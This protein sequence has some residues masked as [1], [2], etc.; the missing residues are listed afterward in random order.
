MDFPI[1]KIRN[2]G[3][4]AH[5]DAG[6][7]TVTER[8]LFASGMTHKIGNV[9]DGN[10]V[11]DWMDQE[12]ERGITIVSAAVTTHW[13]DH[14]IN[15]IDTPGHVDFTAEVERSLRVL[16]GAVVVF[17]SVSGVQPQSETVWR[18]A[19]KYGVPRICLINK[20]D[21]MGANFYRAVDM[22]KD[23]FKVVAVPIQLPIGSESEF[24]GIIDLI[25]QR[26]IRFSRETGSGVEEILDEVPEE[27]QQQLTE[28]R[29]A[30]LENIAE[31]DEEIMM[32]YLDGE[33]LTPDEIRKCIRIG[34]IDNKIV[35]VI[36]GSAM[37]N[38]GM[39]LVSDAIV[40][41]LPSPKDI[42]AISG[43]APRSEDEVVVAHN[44]DDPFCGIAFKVVSDP[45]TGRLVYFRVYSGKVTGGTS[46]LNVTKGRKERMG[47]IVRMVANKREEVEELKAGDIGAS[48]GLKD[49]FTGDTL[50]LE[51]RPLLLETI[52]F[53]EPVISV[54][55]EPKSKAEQEK[56]TD[57]LIKLAEE[58]PT[59]QTKYDEETAQTI[60][61]GMGELHIEV[62]VER[63]KR[64]FS[65]DANLGKPRVSYRE[66]IKKKATA[67]GRFVRQ[68]GGRGQ[69]G[70]VV[71][72]IEPLP[73]GEGFEFDN[74]IVGGKIPREYIPSVQAG[75]KEALTNGTLG[76]YPVVD[77]KVTL[78]DGSFH[79]VDSS[80]MAFK[81]A[82][83][84]GVKA[85]ISKANPQLLEPIMGIEVTTP[86]EH[87]GDVLSD[88]NSRRAQIQ[89]MEAQNDAQ[90]LKAHVP[91]GQMFGYATDLRSATQ[92]R[93]SYSM[94]F[95]HYSEVPE[96]IRE[97]LL[98]QG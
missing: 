7:T 53:P 6:K 82:G 8:V 71:L 79:D 33:E 54:A 14:Q 29:E 16:D 91:L 32:K 93:A 80:E 48:V 49:T 31:F 60:V 20:M 4:I 27:F 11:T 28:Y 21:R 39:L 15:V 74:K 26:V 89:N 17:E 57:G 70:H 94:E 38:W 25:D 92:G 51:N 5:I 24:S 35:P 22:I 19:D 36:C 81:M 77:I 44:E 78:F 34:T 69:Y 73:E 40:D 46:L 43:V 13:R 42:P 18:Q 47:R 66:A 62:L 68:S 23:R 88:L 64:E 56:L 45:Y 52:K 95:D 41:F 30:M 65:V 9:D 83:S 97:E 98:A 37:F 2:I 86:E 90:V 61:S 63:L 84:M 67:E 3:F 12:K 59:F 76:G 96:N 75:V 55:I 85:A 1:D 87:M 50:T 58:D 10:T 72:E